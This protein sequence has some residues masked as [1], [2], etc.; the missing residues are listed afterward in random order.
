MY[1]DIQQ[2]IQQRFV[3]LVREVFNLDLDPPALDSPPSFEMGDLSLAACFELAKRLRQ[4]PRKIAQTLAERSL[5]LD[6]VER[7]SIAGAGYLNFH[8]DRAQA[9]AARTA[10]G[11]WV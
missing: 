7:V 4:P 6:G 2:S 5:P 8:L 1:L 10:H 11:L 9:A 3:A